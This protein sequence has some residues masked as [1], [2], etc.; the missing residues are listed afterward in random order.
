MY[1]YKCKIVEVIDGDT[2]KVDIDVG[3][4]IWMSNLVIRM[5]GIDSP[6]SRTQDPIEKSFGLLSKKRLEELLPVNSTQ[7]V[8]TTVDDKYGR[9]LGDFIVNNES[10]SASL[11]RDAYA[12][13]YNGQNKADVKAL[14]E[15]NRKKLEALGKLSKR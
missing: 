10:V 1:Q 11:V 12:V 7:I 14:H 8:Q 2:V 9:I 13:P 3:F 5:L 4:N 15:L 6:E